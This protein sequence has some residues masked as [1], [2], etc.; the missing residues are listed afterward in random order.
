MANVKEHNKSWEIFS[1]DK[2]ASKL[3]DKDFKTNV[4]N[5]SKE[6][7]KNIDK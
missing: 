4:L 5:M 7:K 2:H 3:L 6:L 1:E